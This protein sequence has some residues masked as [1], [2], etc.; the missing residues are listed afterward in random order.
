[1]DERLVAWGRAVKRRRGSRLP[2]LWL[3][4][5][6]VRGGDPVAAIERLPK[7]GTRGLFGVVF[8]HDQ[9]TGRAALFMAVAKSCRARGVPMVVAGGVGRVGVH[10]RAGRRRGWQD[11][12]LRGFAAYPSQEFRGV[13]ASAHDVAEV[14]R[15]RRAGAKIIFVSPAFAT[16]SHPGAKGLGALRWNN[17]AHYA[18][19]SQAYA[20]GG[21][22]GEK[23]KLLARFCGGAGAISA[24]Q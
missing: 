17:I 1:M 16:G 6:E 18:A 4:T 22:S 5:D 19:D 24:L 10:L 13:T 20:L 8:R 12:G 7:R 9:A 11:G 23:I 14:V 21:I 15:A 3:F 2:V